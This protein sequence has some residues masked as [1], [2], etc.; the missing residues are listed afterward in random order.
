MKIVNGLEGP[1]ILCR[2]LERWFT[3]LHYR[4]RHLL[5]ST[6]F[7]PRENHLLRFFSERK[8]YFFA[9]I[10]PRIRSMT[11]HVLLLWTRYMVSTDI[12][13]FVRTNWTACVFAIMVNMILM[14]NF[15]MERTPPRFW[16]ICWKHLAITIL[17]ATRGRRQRQM[18]LLMKLNFGCD[19][20]ADN[21]RPPQYLVKNRSS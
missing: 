19:S 6:L 11:M 10:S 8:T 12:T 4:H 2:N 16:N 13:V 9:I 14:Q 18:V 15:E 21:A 3:W 7:E 1:L 17:T 20:R 5:S